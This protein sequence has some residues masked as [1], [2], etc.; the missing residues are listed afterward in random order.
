MVVWLHYGT[1]LASCNPIDIDIDIDVT[2]SYS[3]NSS[4]IVVIDYW[5][6]KKNY[7]LRILKLNGRL[8]ALAYRF[9]CAPT[10]V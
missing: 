9:I 4:L 2:D 6:M 5:I 10:D 3:Q 1:L 7:F 8:L